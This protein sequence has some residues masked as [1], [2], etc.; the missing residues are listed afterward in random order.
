MCD[1]C[2]CTQPDDAVKIASP[3]EAKDHSHSHDHFHGHNNHED[4]SLGISQIEIVVR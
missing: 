3:K 1:T 4:F 2:W